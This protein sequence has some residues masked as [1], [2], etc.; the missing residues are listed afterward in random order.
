MHSTMLHTLFDKKDLGRPIKNS[1]KFLQ[2]ALF[3]ICSSIH[4]IHMKVQL[5]RLHKRFNG[6][7]SSKIL[8]IYLWHIFHNMSLNK[9]TPIEKLDDLKSP[10][11]YFAQIRAIVNIF[12]L[13][14]TGTILLQRSNSFKKDVS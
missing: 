12:R 3:F 10:F 6:N 4:V 2:Y 13:C 7:T 5:Y 14:K 1:F 9:L 11:N 8:R